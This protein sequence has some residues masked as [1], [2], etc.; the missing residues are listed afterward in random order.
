MS[1]QMMVIKH[2]FC[3]TYTVFFFEILLRGFE[4][5]LHYKIKSCKIFDVDF[6]A[7]SDLQL[8]L[9]QWGTGNVYLLV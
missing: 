7:P 3:S 4:Q 6:K 5:V 1:D 8:P 9:R 2:D